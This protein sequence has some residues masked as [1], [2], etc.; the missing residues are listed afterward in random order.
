MWASP[1]GSDAAGDNYIG[2]LSHSGDEKPWAIDAHIYED[3][4]TKRLWMTWGAWTMYLTELDPTSGGLKD[5]SLAGQPEFSSHPAGTHTK[6]LSWAPS[7][8]YGGE[9]TIPD[10]WEGIQPEP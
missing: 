9:G 5:T 6:I 10:G 8:A 1:T 4:D 3:A 7:T 2:V